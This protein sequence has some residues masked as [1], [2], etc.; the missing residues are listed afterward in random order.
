MACLIVPSIFMESH[1]GQE[2]AL[3]Q[4]SKHLTAILTAIGWIIF[5][6]KSD[7]FEIEKGGTLFQKLMRYLN[8]GMI[9]IIITLI[10][11]HL[12][13]DPLLTMLTNQINQIQIIE[14]ISPNDIQFEETEKWYHN[15]E[16]AYY[17]AISTPEDTFQLRINNSLKEQ[18]Q[19]SG[20]IEN[21]KKGYL[22]LYYIEK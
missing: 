18:I 16:D 4:S 8:V 9:F 10:P 20:K 6:K 2:V 13:F 7:V 1:P 5:F 17:V 12:I 15:E 11:S 22:G 3:I 21:L 19:S 14:S